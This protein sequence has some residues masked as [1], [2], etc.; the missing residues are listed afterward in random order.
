MDPWEYSP[1]PPPL[2]IS[3]L[4]TCPVT[5]APPSAQNL[6]ITLYLGCRL[7]WIQCSHPDSQNSDKGNKYKMCFLPRVRWIVSGW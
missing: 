5:S 1:P 2:H 6:A 3:I 7:G 4:E